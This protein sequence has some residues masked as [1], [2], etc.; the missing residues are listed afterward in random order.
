MILADAPFHY[1]DRNLSIGIA[2][3][4]AI[5]AATALVWTLISHKKGRKP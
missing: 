2:L 5:L 4:L 1:A 3:L